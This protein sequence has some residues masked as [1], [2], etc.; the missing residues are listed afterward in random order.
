MTGAQFRTLR[1]K[2]GWSVREAARVLGCAAWS[3]TRYESGRRDPPS[4][5]ADKLRALARAAARK[6]ATAKGE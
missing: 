3:I 2:L 5:L 1:L 4:L 6:N